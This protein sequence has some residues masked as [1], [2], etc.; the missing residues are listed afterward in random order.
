MNLLRE[1]HRSLVVDALR[2]GCLVP[3]R[4]LDDYPKLRE[5][6]LRERGGGAAQ[7]LVY[8]ETF[9]LTPDDVAVVYAFREALERCSALYQ[10]KPDPFPVPE[11]LLQQQWLMSE[12]GNAW[13][14]LTLFYWQIRSRSGA[15]TPLSQVVTRLVENEIS[16]LARW[17]QVHGYDDAHI[18]PPPAIDHDTSCDRPGGWFLKRPAIVFGQVGCC[19]IEHPEVGGVSVFLDNPGYAMAQWHAAYLWPRS[20]RWSR[21]KTEAVWAIAREISKMTDWSVVFE[22]SRKIRRTI[23]TKLRSLV[24]QHQGQLEDDFAKRFQVD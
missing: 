3:D 18:P 12:E 23:L 19:G 6:I 17:F 21:E 4:V 11:L 1:E 8:G 7:V 20:S 15:I 2:K 16:R 9:T 22:Q 5:L 13:Q 10:G 24:E 14:D